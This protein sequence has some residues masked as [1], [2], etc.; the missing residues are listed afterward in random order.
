MSE[1]TTTDQGPAPGPVADPT[2]A[3]A[4]APEP[5][6][7][8]DPAPA[9]VDPVAAAAKAASD[10]VA[11]DVLAAQ[12]EAEKLAA[13]AKAALDMQIA[14]AKAM[15][16]TLGQDLHN[17]GSWLYAT[18]AGAFTSVEHAIEHILGVTP[19]V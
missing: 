10:A 14:V 11:A 4:P 16:H 7:V 15:H 3:P 13:E 19:K 8:V 1:E 5:V 9:I 12:V 17:V 2:P 18:A 6:P